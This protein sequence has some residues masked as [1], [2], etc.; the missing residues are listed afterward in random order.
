MGIGYSTGL[1]SVFHSSSFANVHKFEGHSSAITALA[2]SRNTRFLASGDKNGVFMIHPI[3]ESY[4]PKQPI[5]SI[6]FE[7]SIRSIQYSPIDLKYLFILFDDDKLLIFN[8]QNNTTIEVEGEFS[9]C[10]WFN[11]KLSIFTTTDKSGQIISIP[12]LEVTDTYSFSSKKNRSIRRINKISISSDDKSIIF[13]DNNGYSRHFHFQKNH[14]RSFIDQVNPV[15]YNTCSFSRRNKFAVFG[16]KTSGKTLIDIWDLL[17]EEILPTQKF[18]RLKS[19]ETPLFILVH[20]LQPTFYV[21]FAKYA[22]IAS[23]DARV[24]MRNSIDQKDMVFMNFPYIE[25][26]EEFDIKYIETE[27]LKEETVFTQKLADSYVMEAEKRQLMPGDENFPDLLIE[28][29]FYFESQHPSEE[30]EEED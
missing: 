8:Q 1:I 15:R 5:Y 6:E 25:P 20:P 3:D 19:Q 10:V 18:P 12:N 24:H 2:F 28:F 23:L 7:S 11:T 17:Y 21:I 16:Y 30:E 9:T 29:P 4:E 13:I 27:E 26:E 14:L 22:Y